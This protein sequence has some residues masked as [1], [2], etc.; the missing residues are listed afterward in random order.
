MNGYVKLSDQRKKSL[1]PNRSKVFERRIP[2]AQEIRMSETCLAN[3]GSEQ[4]PE[5]FISLTRNLDKRAD[6]IKSVA[7]VIYDAS[8]GFYHGIFYNI[9]PETERVV[10]ENV[11]EFVPSSRGEKYTV[12][13]PP[14]ES[15]VHEYLFTVYYL[16]K[17]L[18]SKDYTIPEIMAKILKNKIYEKTT[19]KYFECPKNMDCHFR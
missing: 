13:C 10:L 15:G 8:V 2:E 17:K 12:F 5:I 14:K 19:R 3:K 18:P 9:E 11:R 7:V 6:L 16:G 4:F 1:P